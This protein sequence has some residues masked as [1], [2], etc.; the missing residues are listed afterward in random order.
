M[1]NENKY[2]RCNQFK[3]VIIF[4]TWIDHDKFKNFGVVSAGFCTTDVENKSISCYGES[5]TLNLKSHPDDSH[6][7][8]NQIFGWEAGM[9]MLK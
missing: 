3:G 2:V 8:T 9:N 4:P 6:I 5:H 7:A 1:H